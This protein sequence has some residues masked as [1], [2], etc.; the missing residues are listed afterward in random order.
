MGAGNTKTGMSAVLLNEF[1]PECVGEETDL[2]VARVDL[3]KRRWRGVAEDGTHVA[4]ALSD[5]SKDGDLLGGGGRKF[6]VRQLSEDVVAIAMPAEAEMAAKIGW[7]LGNRHIPIEVR[8]TELVMENFPTL[9]DSLE[10][11]GIPYEVREDVLRCK[12]HSSGHRH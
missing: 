7:Y 10:R 6:R 12:A 5:P 4:V 9:T 2:P 3:W 1:L 8:D 11:I